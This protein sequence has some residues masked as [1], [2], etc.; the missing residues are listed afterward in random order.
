[1]L[2]SWVMPAPT[3]GLTARVTVRVTDA[4][5]ARFPIDQTTAPPERLPPPL[6]D[7]NEVFAGSGSDRVTPVASWVPALVTVIVYVTDPPGDTRAPPSVLVTTKSGAALRVSV[8]VAALFP[9]VGSGPF[10]PSSNTRAALTTCVCPAGA[11]GFTRTANAAVP[12]PPAATE[13][14]VSR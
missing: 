11:A 13:P 8:S 7:E 2:V 12:D 5:A 4:P 10:A 3:V 1:V 14:I 6:A 9:G